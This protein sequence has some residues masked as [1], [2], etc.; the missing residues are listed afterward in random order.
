[1]LSVGDLQELRPAS[2]I[3]QSALIA[4]RQSLFSL[5]YFKIK[6]IQTI[7]GRQL[8]DSSLMELSRR[9]HIS[10]IEMVSGSGSGSKSNYAIPDAVQQSN[11]NAA[12]FDNVI[13]HGREKVSSLIR[14]W[15]GY[16]KMASFIKRYASPILGTIRNSHVHQCYFYSKRNVIIVGSWHSIRIFI[17]LFAFG[18]SEMSVWVWC[19]CFDRMK[20]REIILTAFRH[21][22]TVD[23]EISIDSLIRWFIQA[24]F[25]VKMKIP[26]GADDVVS[27][28]WLDKQSARNVP[29]ITKNRPINV[30]SQ[31]F[32][33]N[34]FNAS[35]KACRMTNRMCCSRIARCQ[36]QCLMETTGFS[37][38]HGLNSAELVDAFDICLRLCVCVCETVLDSQFV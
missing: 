36:I 6:V 10:I 13:I 5:C 12:H 17:R 37:V 35:T 15:F 23:Y 34:L 14:H 25:R 27:G 3:R 22:S 31:R 8:Y 33:A 18:Q 26:F 29:A 21:Q 2:T 32:N 24:R 30:R 7:F 38:S 16:A 20:M 28:D 11:R 1:M 9:P 4:K 19:F